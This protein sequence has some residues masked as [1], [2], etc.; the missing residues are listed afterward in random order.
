MD[1]QVIQHVVLHWRHVARVEVAPRLQVEHEQSHD[2]RISDLPLRHG[3]A[4]ALLSCVSQLSV[5][6]P[7]RAG[8]PEPID[9][10]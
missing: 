7:F 9:K 5:I 2:L 4:T 6:N 1:K 10:R 3:P 8:A